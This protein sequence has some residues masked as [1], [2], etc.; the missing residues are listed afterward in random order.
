MSLALSCGRWSSDLASG[1]SQS[2]IS[3]RVPGW[4]KSQKYWASWRRRP[5]QPW[6]VGA[7]PNTESGAP[8]VQV[9][10]VALAVKVLGE[11]HPLHVVAGLR[12]VVARLRGCHPLQHDAPVG[13]DVVRA[14]GCLEARC[15]GGGCRH[16][17]HSLP[18]P[19]PAPS[20][21]TGSRRSTSPP[22]RSRGGVTS[23]PPGA[24]RRRLRRRSCRPPV[25]AIRWPRAGSRRPTSVLPPASSLPARRPRCAP[26]PGPPGSLSGCCGSRALAGSALRPRRPWRCR[27]GVAGPASETARA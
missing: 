20:A 10:G 24:G 1:P 8:V 7:A 5:M 16:M 17:H 11:E 21:P 3:T 22:R 9:Q 15:A 12:G 26:A 13:L 6:L 14:A 19:W 18:P 27:P 23:L 25:G 2:W 4:A